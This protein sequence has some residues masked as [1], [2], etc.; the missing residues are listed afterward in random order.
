M[1]VYRALHLSFTYYQIH[2][3][4]DSHSPEN[5]KVAP[6]DKQEHMFNNRRVIS[7]NVRIPGIPDQFIIKLKAVKP[8]TSTLTFQLIALQ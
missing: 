6:L 5:F 2:F 1:H 7:I 4:P 8:A 3:P